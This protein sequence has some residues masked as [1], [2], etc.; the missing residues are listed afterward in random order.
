MKEVKERRA[1]VVEEYQRADKRS[2]QPPFLG[3]SRDDDIA[4]EQSMAR[5]DCP[6]L[7]IPGI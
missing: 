3:I 2:K 6:L 1:P 7:A 5:R 4:K